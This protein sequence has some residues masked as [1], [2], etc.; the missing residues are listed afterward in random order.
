MPFRNNNTISNG[1][2][3]NCT[4]L[5][6]TLLHEGHWLRFSKIRYLDPEGNER[7]WESFGRT[8]RPKDTDSDAVTSIAIYRRMLH[9]DVIVLI[10]QYRPALQAY[11]VEFPTGLVEA[12]E[13]GPDAAMRVLK[14]ETGWHGTVTHMS[15]AFAVDP[16]CS[17]AVA[18]YAT[19]KINGDSF[20][21]ENYKPTPAEGEFVELLMVPFSEIHATL[22]RC[23]KE[24]NIIDSRVACWA[25]GLAMGLKVAQDAE[26]DAASTNQSCLPLDGNSLRTGL[27]TKQAL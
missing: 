3:I 21:N 25:I 22:E 4:H 18:R 23:A 14:R 19:V 20:E 2:H 9:Y 17:S 26:I 6:E 27:L 12:G 7:S 5:G 10:R 13:D 11:T 24:G 15:N 8:T 1:H 16:G